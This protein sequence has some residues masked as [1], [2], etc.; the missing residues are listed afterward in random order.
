MTPRME[1]RRPG[2]VSLPTCSKLRTLNAS[3]KH[4]AYHLPEGH[5]MARILLDIPVAM[6][7]ATMHMEAFTGYVGTRAKTSG[8]AATSTLSFGH[9]PSDKTL[10]TAIGPSTRTTSRAASIG[11]SDAV[12][13]PMESSGSNTPTGIVGDVTLRWYWSTATT[14][15]LSLILNAGTP[16][17]H[18]PATVGQS[19]PSA[20]GAFL[21]P[22]KLSG[23][24]AALI[25]LYLDDMISNT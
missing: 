25:F 5:A 13:T 11:R 6:R 21:R 17:R 24:C 1:S 16:W 3:Y 10:T 2:D 12:T 7:L 19:R 18:G 20:P 14:T 9:K 8:Y 4:I 15:S 22:P 23:N